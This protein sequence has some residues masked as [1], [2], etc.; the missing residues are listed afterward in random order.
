VTAKQNA[1]K[2]SV[3]SNT[4]LLIMKIIVGGLINSVSVLSEAIHSGMDLLAALIAFFAVSQSEKPPD[5]E[6][7]FGH[8]KFENVAG[9]VEAILIFGAALWIVWEAAQKIITKEPVAEPL[10]GLAVMMISGTVNIVVSSVLMKTAR[11]TDSV[12]L[13]ADA[14]HLRTDVYTSFGVGLGLFLLLIT[15]FQIFDPLLAIGVALLIIKAS[16]ELMKKAFFPLLDTCLP[17]DEIM[18]IKKILER[19]CND[20]VEFKNLRTRKAGSERHIDFHL[21]VPGNCTVSEIHELCQQIERSIQESFPG[22]S[23]LIHLEPGEGE[24]EAHE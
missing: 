23:V 12:A 17:E 7:Q 22:A 10:W 19:H 1:A 14:W 3:Y 24:K 4:F 16:F 6:H 18:A 5:E 15:G 9:F 2:I 8:G 21:V 13:E 11:S 20:Y